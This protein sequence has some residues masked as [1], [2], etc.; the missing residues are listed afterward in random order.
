MELNGF[1]LQG[2]P[3][4]SYDVVRSRVGVYVQVRDDMLDTSTNT[5]AETSDTTRLPTR[6]GNRNPYLP[7][8]DHLLQARFR[9]NGDL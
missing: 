3:T 9:D 2:D 1:N 5:A 6:S 7:D 8:E 4:V